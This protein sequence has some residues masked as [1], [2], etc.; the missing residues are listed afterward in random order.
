M[1]DEAQISLKE[2]GLEIIQ[3][4]EEFRDQMLWAGSTYKVL[5]AETGR[6]DKAPR[7]VKTGE[8]IS[9]TSPDGWTDFYTAMNSGYPVIGCR[10]TAEDPYTVIDLDKAKNEDDNAF[11]K[12]V[13]NSFQ[14]Y[15][16]WSA[17]GN[18]VHIILKGDPQAGRRK[19]NVE[20]YSQERY[21]I[22]TGKQLRGMEEREILDGGVTLENLIKSLSLND[23]PDTLPVLENKDENHSDDSILRSMF[24]AEN[25]KTIENLYRTT[26]SSTDDWSTLDARLAQHICFYTQNHNQALRLFRGSALYRGDGSKAGYER[27]DKYEED[28]LLRRTF[29]RAWYLEE[30]RR[31]ERQKQ[32]D[33]VAAEFIEKNKIVAKPVPVEEVLHDK[34]GVVLET[35]DI[36]NF[37][38]WLNIEKL[39]PMTRPTGLIGEIS[40]YIYKSAPRPVKEVAHAGAL[41]LLS[42][43]AGRHYNINNTGLGLYIVLL[44]GTGRGKEAASSGVS[45]IFEAV[46]QN[47][48]VIHMFRGP[49]QLASGQGLMRM[50]ADDE[51]IP[52]KV[53]ILSEF[54]HTMNIITDGRANAADQRTRQAMLDLFSKNAW[55]S[56]IQ[57]T[58]YSDKQ[59][60]TS[61]ISAP[62]LTI[63]GDTTPSS[64]FK[65]IKVDHIAEGFIPRFMVIEYDGPR[66]E[67]NYNANKS[68][69]SDLIDRMTALVMQVMSMRDANTCMAINF[70]NGEHILRAFEHYCDTMINDKEDDDKTELWNRAGLKAFRLAGLLAVSDNMF[71]PR[72][73]VEN[74][75]LAVEYV[76]RDMLS[77]MIR[78]NSGEFG[79]GDLQRESILVREIFKYFEGQMDYTKEKVE[80]H[81]PSHGV[82]PV[83]YLTSK[84]KDNPA[85]VNSS[86]GS[87]NE[88]NNCISAFVDEGLIKQ[89]NPQLFRTVSGITI[90]KDE[91]IYGLGNNYHSVCE[92]YNLNSQVEKPKYE[93]RSAETDKDD[94]S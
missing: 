32:S 38:D 22:C 30:Q 80:D 36:G 23:N 37:Q 29:A 13:M 42:G 47:A 63:L 81:Y 86:K 20:V 43:I 82:M 85:F 68:V 84:F 65:S 16:E 6:R 53:M 75:N 57:E 24:S 3:I 39:P 9:V 91:K 73:S 79:G 21:I 49:S 28:Y 26:P 1:S 67:A 66:V 10:L 33:E 4:P 72:V 12:K 35:L 17:S 74:A 60:D 93:P 77:Y 94:S 51:S 11:A 19:R 50:L 2:L 71:E 8:R 44:A 92:S 18:G 87:R 27:V 70:E 54:G 59:K 41:S 7:N 48:P 15:T 61:V 88:I 55:G 76:L 62:N 83:H 34:D 31:K 46:G 45:N 14:S 58:A 64:Y 69:P 56:T 78:F 5:D 89:V 52:S 25:G 90:T 40:D